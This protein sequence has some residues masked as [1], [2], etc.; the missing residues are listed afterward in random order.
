MQTTSNIF[1]VQQAQG[2]DHDAFTALV[3]SHISMVRAITLALVGSLNAS[4]DVTQEVFL[5][6]WKR[7][8]TLRSVTSFT[9]WLRQISRN[10]SR[11]HQ[12]KHI[13]RIKRV[14]PDTEAV[15]Q[16]TAIG[17]AEKAMLKAEELQAL[18]EAMAELATD[19][20]E[21]IF[22]FYREGQSIRQVANMFDLSEGAMK[23]RI[24][25]AR[26]RLRSDV[27]ARLATGLKRTA[28]NGPLIAV[29]VGL[30]ASSPARA[31]ASN[32]AR[33]AVPVGIAALA[34]LLAVGLKGCGTAHSPIA[35][36]SV[37]TDAPASKPILAAASEEEEEGF[38]DEANDYVPTE[39]YMPFAFSDRRVR[40]PVA[41]GSFVL[42]PSDYMSADD[43]WPETPIG[44]A[45]IASLNA[46]NTNNFVDLGNEIGLTLDI[47]AMDHPWEALLTIEYLKLARAR[48]AREGFVLPKTLTP[49]IK[50]PTYELGDLLD[51]TRSLMASEDQTVADYAGMTAVRLLKSSRDKDVY[52]PLAAL[53]L[54]LDVLDDTE[55]AGVRDAA[56]KSLIS[57]G[58]PPYG[59]MNDRRWAAFDATMA[60]MPHSLSS[61]NYLYLNYQKF[62]YNQSLYE[63]DLD[64]AAE[65]LR[66]FHDEVD[67]MCA[68]G[69]DE[70]N[71][72]TI[73][74]E[75]FRM[76]AHHA[77]DSGKLPE[78][79]RAR[80][81]VYGWRCHDSNPVEAGSTNAGRVGADGVWEAW[82]TATPWTACFERAAA[83][84]QIPKDITVKF[85]VSGDMSHLQVSRFNT[86]DP[87][88]TR[89]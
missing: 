5:E 85:T 23:K 14:E 78:D 77:I 87:E 13:R 24:S 63:G 30:V 62:A 42:H 88:G 54:A 49:G 21:A 74:D 48:D 22:L 19:D 56:V 32:G 67:H 11:D 28:S 55:H 64:R 50:F 29:I 4:D 59:V 44:E 41:M 6:A 83:G 51:V 52:D 18:E 72:D 37:A 26:Q 71:C 38:A 9:P 84:A 36:T 33:M 25:R 53:D 15:I 57:E 16:A 75:A 81:V 27:E 66:A 31:T 79:W 89:R 73:Q 82:E 3:T 20:R 70:M 60:D 12:R 61:T 86:Y 69:Q 17:D 80:L 7:L 47:D 43:P 45:F 58:G 35:G 34:L 46:P 8:P 2:G 39:L 40:W 1:L 65:W 76:D 68:P 10:R